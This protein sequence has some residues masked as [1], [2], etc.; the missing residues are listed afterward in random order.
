VIGDSAPLDFRA[1][2]QHATIRESIA[3]IIPGYEQLLQ[4]NKN[5]REFHIEGR[6]F[7]EPKFKTEGGRARFHAF[8]LPA[9]KT[10]PDELRLMTIRSE[11]QFNTVVYEEEDLYRNQERRDV[12]L[13]NPADIAARGLKE[14][15]RVTIRSATGAMEGI[16][17]RPFDIRAGNIA[18]YYPEANC[19]IARSA[20][21][22]SR[23]PSFKN[24]PVRVEKSMR[25]SVVPV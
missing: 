24:T 25:L 7:H 9:Q 13:M 17:I 10:S 4:I 1:M 11:G 6:V 23:T 8:P 14:D 16:L 21:P 15:D 22:K 12:V 5:K 18:M 2:Q 3:A 20:D 19:L